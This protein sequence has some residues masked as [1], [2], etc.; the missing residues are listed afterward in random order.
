MVIILG[1]SLTGEYLK[2]NTSCRTF[3]RLVEIRTGGE[4]LATVYSIPV[5]KLNLTSEQVF[6]QLQANGVG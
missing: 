3:L 6:E 1:L 4:T 5:S 2:H